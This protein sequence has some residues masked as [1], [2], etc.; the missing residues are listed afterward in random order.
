M[1]MQVLLRKDVDRLGKIG[2][3]VNVK[4]GYGRNYLLAR[5]LAM[6]LTAGN[7]RRVEI[8]KKKAE[9]ERKVQEQELTVLAGRL[10]EVSIT[11]SAKANEEGHLFGS[12]TAAQIA[13]MLQAEG[14]KVE[15]KMVQLT[16]PVKELGVVEVPIQLKPDL[17][18]SCKIWVVAE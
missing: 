11:I 12:V 10:K 4:P 16:D 15:E 17:V 7:V 8:E 9:E 5:G 2:D 3:V 6:P 13:Q 14:Y 18:S 1:A